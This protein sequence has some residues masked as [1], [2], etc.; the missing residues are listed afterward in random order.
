MSRT[1]RLIFGLALVLN[2]LVLA[3][4]PQKRTI[5]QIKADPGS[6]AGKEV[7]VEGTVTNSFGVFALPGAY[8]V[9]DGTGRIWVISERSGGVPSS[10][11]RV[12][13]AGKVVNGF[14]YGGQAYG[15]VIRETQRDTRSTR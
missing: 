13:L 15:T 10:G 12:R 3:G 11:A 6:F 2:A 8:E 14:T 9:D 1:A 4:C 5:A 7:G